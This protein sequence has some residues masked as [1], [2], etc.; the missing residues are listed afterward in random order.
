MG[1]PRQQSEDALKQCDGRL[2]EAALLLSSND[3]VEN[4]D[5][6]HSTGSC[7]SSS[8]DFVKKRP[9]VM[10]T[11]TNGDAGIICGIEMKCN[12]LSVCVIDDCK[13]ADVP[14]AELNVNQ[15]ELT[16]NCEEKSGRAECIFSGDYYN[17]ELSGW[18]P[19]LEPWK[20]STSWKQNLRGQLG[21]LIK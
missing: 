20:C 21:N 12:C 5:S 8:E 11:K 3:N 19:F 7:A 9:R 18:E 13:D 14:L 1:F 15:L 2:E 16:Q 10:E 4:V 6:M 17:R